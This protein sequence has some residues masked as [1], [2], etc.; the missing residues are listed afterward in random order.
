MEYVIFI[1]AIIAVLIIA[2]ILAWPIKKMVK[3]IL[4]IAVGILLLIL[5]NYIGRAFNFNIPF[6]N[7]TAGISGLLGLPGIVL[8]II[9][10]IIGF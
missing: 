9:L 6:N 3:L 4:N 10:K 5:V 8:L 2:K 1:G 7:V